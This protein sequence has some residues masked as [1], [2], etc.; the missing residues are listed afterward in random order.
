MI[1]KCLTASQLIVTGSMEVSSYVRTTA[2]AKIKQH[3]VSDYTR[4]PLWQ[5]RPGF[6]QQ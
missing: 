3:P 1:K 2:S 6:A 5:Q 4:A